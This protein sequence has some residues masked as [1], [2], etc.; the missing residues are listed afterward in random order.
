MVQAVV[1]NGYVLNVW[2]ATGRGVTRVYLEYRGSDRRGRDSIKYCLHVTGDNNNP[3]GELT[4]D[5]GSRATNQ[6]DSTAAKLVMQHAAAIY[7]S[8]KID[9]DQAAATRYDVPAM[10]ADV[11]DTLVA[12]AIRRARCSTIWGAK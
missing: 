6:G 1:G 3:P 2:R 12:G 8:V 11:A 10:A 9:C 5:V 7:D 4:V